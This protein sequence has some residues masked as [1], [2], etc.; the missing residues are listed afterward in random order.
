MPVRLVVVCTANICRSPLAAAMLDA[1][2]RER[3]TA[4]QV[5]VD[6]A[7]I[8]A[9]RGDPAAPTSA[10]IARDLGL[11]LDGHRS[12]PVDDDLDDEHVV[13]LTMTVRQRDLLATVD[14]GLAARCFTLGELARLV[15]GIELDGL[16][17]AGADRVLEV[18]RRADACRTA[19]RPAHDPGATSRSETADDIADPY[20]RSDAHYLQMAAAV[21]EAIDGLAPI[22]LG[23]R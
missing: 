8:H 21:R 18:V 20:G 9:R 1:E 5:S 4:T 15:R 6:S 12:R 10:A 3:G 22:L 2:V 17:D 7:G 23:A 11:D 19:D 16:P 14:S 13:L